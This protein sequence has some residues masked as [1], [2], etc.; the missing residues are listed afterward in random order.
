[1]LHEQRLIERG[2]KGI[3]R[4]TRLTRKHPPEG[5]EAR[6]EFR[7]ELGFCSFD[8]KGRFVRKVRFVLLPVRE[9]HNPVARGLSGFQASNQVLRSG[10]QIGRGT[11]GTSLD[12]WY[13]SLRAI[14][15]MSHFTSYLWF[16]EF[17]RKKVEQFRMAWGVTTVIPIDRSSPVPGQASSPKSDSTAVRENA[18]LSGEVI[19]A[20]SRFAPD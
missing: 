5:S 1:M 8:S 16:N 14:S 10:E 18:A 15:R 17:R 13:V 12:R 9:E 3:L 7:I 19:A 11:V 6:Q 4:L 20:A 2:G